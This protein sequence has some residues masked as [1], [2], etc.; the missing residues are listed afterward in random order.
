VIRIRP[1]NSRSVKL[2]SGLHG[3]APLLSELILELLF[4][5]GSSLANLLELSLKVDNPLLLLRRMLQQ[6]GPAFGP[7]C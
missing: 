5:G 1:T 2:R 4:L 3:L 7:L 6:V